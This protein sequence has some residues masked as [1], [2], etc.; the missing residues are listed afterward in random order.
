[1]KVVIFCGGEGTRLREVT[2]SIPKVLAEIGGKPILWHIIKLYADQGFKEFVLCLGYKGHLIKRY[3]MDLR[4]KD[5]DFSINSSKKLNFH[6]DNSNEW[7]ITFVDTGE[8]STKSERLKQIEKYIDEDIFMV[9]YGD[10]LADIDLKKLIEFHKKHKKIATLTAYRAPSPL[11]V[12]EFEKNGR[13]TNFREKPILDKWSNGGFFVF[14][15]KIF[16][17]LPLG[18]LEDKVFPKLAENNEIFAYE[19][20]KFWKSMDTFKDNTEFNKMWEEG[21]ILWIKR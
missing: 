1:M 3:F 4:W 6:T 15:K 18:E 13:I 19:H 9:T 11:G 5:N 8:K 10:G 12:I 2:E 7:N 21:K 17:Y 20:E 14:N 16:D